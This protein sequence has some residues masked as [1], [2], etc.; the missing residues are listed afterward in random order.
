MSKTRVF[1]VPTSRASRGCDSVPS[2][3]ELRTR[4]NEKAAVIENSLPA[5][6]PVCQSTAILAWG[7]KPWAVINQQQPGSGVLMRQRKRASAMSSTAVSQR[8]QGG[9]ILACRRA[10]GHVSKVW[11]EIEYSPLERRKAARRL[12]CV[13]PEWQRHKGYSLSELMSMG[14]FGISVIKER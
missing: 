6:K 13:E 7:R 14:N 10:A 4:R 12:Q 11:K 9:P 1:S 5:W 8:T 3:N 2:T